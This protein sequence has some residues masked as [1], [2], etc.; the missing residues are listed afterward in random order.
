LGLSLGAAYA[1]TNRSF[2]TAIHTRDRTQAASIAQGQIEF[3][4]DRSLKGQINSLITQYGNSKF[5]F[6]D[7]GPSAGSTV[8]ATAGSYCMPYG[9]SNNKSI[10]DIT[11]SYCDGSS[12]CG[13]A[14]VFTIQASWIA[15]GSGQQNQLKLYYKPQR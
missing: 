9:P 2:R 14:N 5:C 4:K 6:V 10:Y 3:L 15:A 8:S 11:V 7:N 12:G 1:L 13:P